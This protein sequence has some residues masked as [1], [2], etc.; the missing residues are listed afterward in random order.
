MPGKV[1]THHVICT[2]LIDTYMKQRIDKFDKKLEKRLDYTSLV[3][4]VEA[5]LFID[6]MD[7]AN[8]EEHGDGSNNLSD[9]SYEDIMTEER[10][11]KYG[12]DNV[13]YNKFI[14]A[15]LIMDVPVEGPWRPTVKICVE[16][17]DGAK[18]RMY[19]HKLLT[20]TR[21]YDLEYYYRTHYHYFANFIFENLYS[22]VDSEGRQFLILEYFSGNQSDGT[23]ITVASGFIISRGGNKH[24][25]KTTRGW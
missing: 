23:A 6:D 1:A 18:V 4:D 16:Y 12:I 19:L 20:D 5:D 3:N 15:E 24:T 11:K 14:S 7:E 8:E 10:P 9:E 22:K 17:L 2:D 13:S 21:E 25:K